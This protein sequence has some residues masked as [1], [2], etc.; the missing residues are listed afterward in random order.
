MF[1]VLIEKLGIDIEAHLAADP[2]LITVYLNTMAELV[3]TRMILSYLYIY[4]YSFFFMA[5]CQPFL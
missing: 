1:E 4:L 5:V 2:E 3:K